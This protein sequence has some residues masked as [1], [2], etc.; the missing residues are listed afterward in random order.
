MLKWHLSQ[1]SLKSTSSSTSSTPAEV[2]GVWRHSHVPMAKAPGE[3]A[4]SNTRGDFTAATAWPRHWVYQLYLAVTTPM[5]CQ[6]LEAP[7]RTV[8]LPLEFS[9]GSHRSYLHPRPSEQA[10]GN[11]GA[12]KP[13]WHSKWF[14]N[15]GNGEFRLFPILP[16]GCCSPRNPAERV[17]LWESRVPK[18]QHLFNSLP[19]ADMK[20]YDWMT[21]IT[22]CTAAKMDE[23]EG[24]CDF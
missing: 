5:L 3:N 16:A 21:S 24:G 7:A 19:W 22:F 17:Q 18:K 23:Q 10:G 14:S 11:C 15:P 20:L 13:S 9:P 1:D 4:H 12:L 2:W 6:L 8:C